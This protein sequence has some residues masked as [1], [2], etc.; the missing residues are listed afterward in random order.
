MIKKCLLRILL[1]PILCFQVFAQKPTKYPSLLWEITGNGLQKPS[2]LYGTMHVSKKVA[3]HL[4]DRFFEAL[5]NVDVVG[6]E[7]SPGEWLDNMGKY[8]MFS[9]VKGQIDFSQVSYDFYG[10]AFKLSFPANAQI[11]ALLSNDADIINGLLYRYVSRRENF[12]EA[13]YID[14]FIYQT[15]SKWGKKLISLEDFKVSE[16]LSQRSAIPDAD[17]ESEYSY[18]GRRGK[19]YYSLSGQVEDAYRRGDLDA[20]DSLSRL[21]NTSKNHQKYLI[22]ERNIIMART[23]DS[24][25]QKQP[26][27]SGI[28]AAHLPGPDGVIELLRKKG[29]TVTPVLNTS[30]KKGKKTQEKLEE[31]F[32]PL[33]ASQKYNT[34]SLF[35]CALGGG[36]TTIIDEEAADYNLYTDMTNGAYYTVTRMR[37]FGTLFGVSRDMMLK[38]LDSLF[39]EN[40]PGK[41]ISKKEITTNTGM[42][43][44]DITNLTRRGD[45][46]RCQ[47]Y[48]TDMEL[49][50][51]KLGGHGKFVKDSEGNRF[52]NS[53]KF[54]SKQDP[55]KTIVY[56]PPT[57]GFEIK[58][59][60]NYYYHKNYVGK[61][62]DR[63]ENLF[64]Y[65]NSKDVSIGVIQAYYNEYDYLEEDTF[66]LNILCSKFLKNKGYKKD[67]TRSLGTEQGFPCLNFTAQ[68]ADGVLTGKIFIK[69]VHYY[70]VFTATKPGNAPAAAAY[71]GS[72][73]LT[74]FKYLNERK[75][76]S[77]DNY[78]FKVK[79]EITPSRNTEISDALVNDYKKLDEARNKGKYKNDFEY[80]FKNKSY[81]S[82][83]VAEHVHIE[84]QKY[85]DYDYREKKLIWNN[86]V[87]YYK[88]T[89]MV[90]TS[91]KPVYESDSLQRFEV[92]M[93]DTAT[94]RAIKSLNI[95]KQGLVYTLSAQYDTTIGMSQWQ[96]EF[97]KTFKPA[98]TLI[99]KDVFEYKFPQMLK[100]LS[101]ADSNKKY[102]AS[103]SLSSVGFEKRCIDDFVSY[104]KDTAVFF[105]LPENIQAILLVNGGTMESEK[106]IPLYK[107]LYPKLSENSYLQICL[108]K[109]LA[110][111]RTVNSYSAMT[112][113]YK[114]EPPLV[115]DESIVSSVFEP[116]Y[117]S[118][119]MSKNLFP[120]L[121]ELTRFEEYKAPVYRLLAAL[122]E[123]GLLNQTAY[124]THKGVLLKEANY[125][126]KRFTAS[127][128][129]AVNANSNNTGLED[130]VKSEADRIAQ[131]ISNS[132]NNNLYNSD[133]DYEGSDKNMLE[134]FAILLAPLYSSDAQVKTFFEKTGKIKNEKSLLEIS[135]IMLKNKIPVNDTIWAYYSKHNATR[136]KLYRELGEIK[137]TT[138]FDKK[139]LTQEEFCKSALLGPIA[140]SESTYDYD[141]DRKIEKKQT[142]TVSFIKK[143]EVSNKY[144][145]GHIYFFK[146]HG[147]KNEKKMLAWVFV[148]AS[149][150]EVSPDVDALETKYELDDSEKE[151][152][153]I[154]ETIVNF[155]NRYRNRCT[156][157]SYK[158]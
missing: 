91:A 55:A 117:D 70:L 18:S 71:L 8:D 109:G 45:Y 150:N 98:D 116:L 2:Y 75:E 76:I 80:E 44:F 52:F 16:I 154:S 37:T 136:V 74:D 36:F 17:A 120:S 60:G 93:K 152:E 15:G 139:Y 124:L 151:E 46:Q 64:A 31:T 9:Q 88:K 111:L 65:D 122:V 112:G 114:D 96:T 133:D 21:M 43:G 142:D 6:L 97:F 107:K 115:G 4:S 3:F 146:R 92:I 129:Q 42:K 134:N 59:P 125:E 62:V 27:F 34:D 130:L 5:E 49:I 48:A 29:Y 156:D 140:Y 7:T 38:K 61:N 94:V 118:L 127:N 108:L 135:L 126:F 83:S 11:A 85:N 56:S 47:I 145:K 51:I 50:M 79:D 105:A 132:I 77:D 138:K 24:V 99:G 32:K 73:K 12:E 131:S 84:Y 28:G 119:E 23:M 30:D 35:S 104:M 113:L 110:Y 106:V 33:A 54:Y 1:P 121:L 58:I 141:A 149:K 22:D 157:R 101:S 82:P 89:G 10:N 69:G 144:E 147:I 155:Y 102:A 57:G 25:M 40:I 128:S 53:L 86:A 158:Y 143:V 81:Y 13:T 100:D 41:I 39:Y 68:K 19:D 137:E 103:Q 14:L 63:A 72:F 90:V 153:V 95:L 20:L 66:E 78:H 87:K 26:L 123:R 67:I 148:R